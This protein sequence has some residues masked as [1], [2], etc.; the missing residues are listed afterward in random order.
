MLWWMSEYQQFEFSADEA[1]KIDLPNE[2]IFHHAP[3]DERKAFG[4]SIKGHLTPLYDSAN[5]V[6]QVDA[7]DLGIDHVARLSPKK[8]G[9]KKLLI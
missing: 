8:E 9:G 4:D 5:T 3:L 6:L 2:R 1:H 7:G